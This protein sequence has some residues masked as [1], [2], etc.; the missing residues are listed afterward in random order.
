MSDR[1]ATSAWRRRQRRLRAQWRHEQQ[2][3]AMVLASV[4]ALVPGGHRA[5]RFTKPEACHQ[6]QGGSGASAARRPTGTGPSTSGDA[7]CYPAGARGA[8]AA[9]APLLAWPSLPGGD[10][11]DASSVHFLLEM[12]LK[13]PEKVERMRRAERR[14]LAREKEEKELEEKRG[15]E[16]Q[17]VEET[18]ARP[19]AEFWRERSQ[20][21]SSTQRRRKKRKKKKLPRGGR[22]HRRQRQWYVRAF[23]AV[24]MTTETPLLLLNTVIDVP[25]AQFVL[26]STS[27]VASCIW[28]SLVRCSVFAFGVQDYGIF[29]VITSVMVS[30]CS[31][32]WSDSGYM[33][34]VSLRGLVE[35]FHMFYT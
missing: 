24:F 22:A 29:W 7:P 2:T 1:D 6:H 19:T 12:A 14:R 16:R 13:T 8:G 25:V 21:S 11:I 33:L 5:R 30:V 18:I 32:P 20:A 17:K 31:T 3:V 4:P 27:S 35:E 15:K 34:G 26:V 10:A 9:G 28:Q 23:R